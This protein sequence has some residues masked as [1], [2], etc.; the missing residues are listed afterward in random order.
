MISR[1]QCRKTFYHV[2]CILTIVA[3]VTMEVLCLAEAVDVTW[4]SYCIFYVVLTPVIS[5][6]YV[7]S[8]C[9][10]FSYMQTELNPAL[11]PEWVKMAWQAAN[12]LLSLFTFF[13]VRMLIVTEVFSGL[14]N[15]ILLVQLSTL[16]TDILPIS[17]VVYCH[18]RSFKRQREV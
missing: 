4:Y 16:I 12:F 2:L 10:L 9:M 7:A 15:T 6:C 13:L 17:Y 8:L 11:K 14:Q 1:A 18:R 5:V 3:V